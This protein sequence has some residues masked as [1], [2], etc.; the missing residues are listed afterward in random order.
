MEHGNPPLFTPKKHC[1]IR[2]AEFNCGYDAKTAYTVLWNTEYPEFGRFIPGLP[3]ASRIHFTEDHKARVPKST[4]RQR[5]DFFKSI[6]F[7]RLSRILN[8][9]A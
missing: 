7:M 1:L 2:R 6:F 4:F 3:L 8:A 9:T 5:R